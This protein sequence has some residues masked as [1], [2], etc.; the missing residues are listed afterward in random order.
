MF[1]LVCASAEQL[2]PTIRSRVQAFCRAPAGGGRGYI[3]AGGTSPGAGPAAAA[4][5]GEYRPHGGALRRGEEAQAFSIA[6]AMAQGLLEPRGAQPS[7]G[8]GPLQKDRDLFGRCWCGWGA[9]FGTAWCCG[10]GEH[11]AGGSPELADKLGDLPMKCLA[12]L[13]PAE[14]SSAKAGAQRQPGAAC[15][16]PFAPACGSGGR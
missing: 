7:A 12:R 9:V 15:H 6:S 4:L 16:G 8:G 10:P 11:C 3:A 13:A 2:L 14:R 5:C 1:I